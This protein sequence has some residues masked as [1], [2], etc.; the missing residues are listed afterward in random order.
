MGSG[1]LGFD[2]EYLDSLSERAYIE[3]EKMD[4]ME[5]LMQVNTRNQWFDKH[6]LGAFENPSVI[7]IAE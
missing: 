4:F 6:C 2:R 3:A 1:N 5:P 7:C